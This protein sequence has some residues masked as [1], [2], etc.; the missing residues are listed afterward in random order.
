MTLRYIRKGLLVLPILFTT[1]TPLFTSTVSA[2]ET[3]TNSSG[4]V[5]QPGDQ[6]VIDSVSAKIEKIISVKWDSYRSKIVDQ[7]TK[8]RDSIISLQITTEK[9][10]KMYY[11]VSTVINT[12]NKGSVSGRITMGADALLKYNSKAFSDINLADIRAIAADSKAMNRLS[13]IKDTLAQNAFA[14]CTSKKDSNGAFAECRNAFAINYLKALYMGAS[15]VQLETT[16]ETDRKYVGDVMSSIEDAIGAIEGGTPSDKTVSTYS[17]G[18]DGVMQKW[19]ISVSHGTDHDIVIFR[20]VQT[21][22][23]TN[24]DNIIKNGVQWLDGLSIDDL[25]ALVNDQNIISAIYASQPN[26]TS[27][28]IALCQRSDSNG[29]SATCSGKTA[30]T[31]LKSLFLQAKMTEKYSNIAWNQSFSANSATSIEHWIQDVVKGDLSGEE[32]YYGVFDSNG[33]LL[34]KIQILIGWKETWTGT[35]KKIS[36]DEITMY[37]NDITAKQAIY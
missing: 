1:I 29:T 5:A 24:A 31:F 21:K 7:L 35:S 34:Q 26:L 4:Y 3:F 36:Y 27:D 16:V 8:Y 30:L 10:A 28:A 11:I 22:S 17:Y 15:S 2:F 32:T 25:K 19:Q 12:L 23:L 37:F 9:K 6:I 33:K 13:A 18:A 14:K 20:L